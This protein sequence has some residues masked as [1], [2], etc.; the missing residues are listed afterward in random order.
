MSR[1]PAMTN[2]RR[3]PGA[4]G[5]VGDLGAPTANERWMVAANHTPRPATAKATGTWAPTVPP[6]HERTASE[7]I[8][9]ASSHNAPHERAKAGRSSSS[10]RHNSPATQRNASS[11]ATLATAIVVASGP[12][13]STLGTCKTA[14]Q[15]RKPAARGIR[16][17]PTII[18]NACPGARARN[19]PRRPATRKIPDSTYTGAAT[20]VVKM[21]GPPRPY[22]TS[23]ATEIVAIPA[24][25]STQGEP[26]TRPN[27]SAMSPGRR[28]ATTMAEATP[29]AR[30]NQGP[31]TAVGRANDDAVATAMRS[32]TPRRTAGGTPPY[33]QGA[34]SAE[35]RGGGDRDGARPWGV[36]PPLD[37]VKV[38]LSG[39]EL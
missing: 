22:C 17:S 9:A 38:R 5:I 19:S 3:S 4:P 28:M 32:T 33:R 34:P 20:G 6:S 31:A 1:I 2:R 30:A 8:D 23:G 26:I 13:A 39:R 16:L 29:K 36:A 15:M 18:T 10:K 24:A 25:T 27:A 14:T 7:P 37:V 12:N 35:R 11:P 21:P